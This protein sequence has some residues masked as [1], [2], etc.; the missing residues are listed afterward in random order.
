MVQNEIGRTIPLQI[1]E[2]A[3]QMG[4]NKTKH[5]H[6]YIY[7]EGEYKVNECPAGVGSRAARRY[8]NMDN[9]NKNKIYI[10]DDW[11]LFVSNKCKSDYQHLIN[12]QHYSQGK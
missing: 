3:K 5:L 10:I 4:F 7:I 8:Y 12:Q 11:V 6:K 1:I 9:A 2:K